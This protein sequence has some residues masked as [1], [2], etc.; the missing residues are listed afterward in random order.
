MAFNSQD[1]EPFAK[2]TI[3]WF[4]LS[5]S[6]GHLFQSFYAPDRS[7]NESGYWFLNREAVVNS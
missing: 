7:L 1:S 4:A 2:D 3:R 5:R 6:W